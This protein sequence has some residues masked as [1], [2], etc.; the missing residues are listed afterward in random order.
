MHWKTILFYNVYQ[1]V[2][3]R[4]FDEMTHQLTLNTSFF[5]FNIDAVSNISAMK[6]DTPFSWL[7][8]APTLARILSTIEISASEQGTK[9]PNCAINTTTPIWNEFH[10]L[11]TFIEPFPK[12]RFYK[13][14]SLC[15]I[16]R[17]LYIF[18]K[19]MHC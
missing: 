7:S 18:W 16:T 19:E 17:S 13:N 2:I 9:Q 6:V 11:K 1:Y 4:E 14:L 15:Y 12:E 5:T 3:L 8:P 10:N